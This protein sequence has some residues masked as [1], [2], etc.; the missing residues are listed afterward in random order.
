ML[1]ANVYLSLRDCKL[2]RLQL[3][4]LSSLF[5]AVGSIVAAVAT[6]FTMMYAIPSLY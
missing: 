6:N 4:L 3:V 2:I 1:H 5:F